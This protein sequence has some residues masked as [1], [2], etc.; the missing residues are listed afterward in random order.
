MKRL[1]VLFLILIASM[2]LAL[3][4]PPRTIPPYAG[5]SN[6]QHDGQPAWCQNKDINGFKAN[7]GCK[8][9]CDAND[10]GSDCKTWCR[11]PACKCDHGCPIT[12]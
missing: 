11:T 7:C 10:R 12:E 1:T 9:T 2:A 3:Q 5:D 8:R 4:Q 6:P